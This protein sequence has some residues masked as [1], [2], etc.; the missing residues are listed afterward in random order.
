MSQW[1]KVTDRMPELDDDG[2]SYPV[3]LFGKRNHVETYKQFVGYLD[4]NGVFYF[5]AEFDCVPCHIVKYWMPLPKRQNNKTLTR[6]VNKLKALQSNSDIEAAHNQADK[7]LCD[8]LNSLG[9][10]DVVKE[11]ENLEKWYA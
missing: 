2:Y 8:L 4:S 11:F 6:I 10:D 9:Y 5:D 7:I 1:I 3:L